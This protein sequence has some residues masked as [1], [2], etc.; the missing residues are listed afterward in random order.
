MSELPRIGL[1]GIMQELYE[2]LGRDQAEI[3]HRLKRTRTGE[4]QVLEDP[5]EALR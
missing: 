5:E 2:I 3:L 1:L 4:P